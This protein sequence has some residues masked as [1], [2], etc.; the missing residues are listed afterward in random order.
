MAGKPSSSDAAL[1]SH[2]C[3]LLLYEQPNESTLQDHSEIQFVDA[4]SGRNSCAFDDIV[5]IHVCLMKMFAPF[6]C[7]WD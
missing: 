2:Q 7:L 4:G 1:T 6:V 5:C 3:R